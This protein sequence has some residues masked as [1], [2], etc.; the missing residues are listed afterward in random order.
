VAN[1]K[2]NEKTA[3]GNILKPILINEEIFGIDLYEIGLGE[4]IEGY[5][6]EMISG[7][8][9]VRLTLEKYLEC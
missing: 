6:D 1:V 4:K 5:F 8:G 9:A 7:V 2:V 3:S